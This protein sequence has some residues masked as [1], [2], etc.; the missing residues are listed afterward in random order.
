MTARCCRSS[1]STATRSPIRPCSR[2]CARGA[3]I[4]FKVTATSRYSSKATTRRR[5]TSRWPPTLDTAFDRIR[6]IQAEAR[7]PRHQAAADLADDRAAHSQ[8]LDRPEGRR[9]PDGRGL[10]ARPS[11]ADRRSAQQPGASEI[12][13]RVDASYQPEELFDEDGRLRAELAGA[14]AGRRAAH[15]RQSACQWRPVEARTALPDF[16]DLRRGGPAPGQRR[17]RS[18]ARSWGNSCAT[19]SRLNAAPRNFRVFGPDETASNRLR[20]GLRGHR[21]GLDGARSIP[22]DDHLAPGRPGDGNSERTSCARAGSRV[23][24]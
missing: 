1:I 10:L 23:I 5:C 21:T 15:G 7:T 19:S 16:R 8:G 11:G 22:Y 6:A 17:S 18:D 2:A 9:R 12:A 3:E 24:C 4:L 13:R 20:R 14:G